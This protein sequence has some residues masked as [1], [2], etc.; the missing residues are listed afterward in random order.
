MSSFSKMTFRPANEDDI[1]QLDKW[2]WCYTDADL[3]VVHGWRAKGVETAVAE[4]GGN[5]VGSL[6]GKVAVVAVI[7]PFIHDPDAKGPDIYA[8]VVGMERILAYEGAAAG[9][10]EAYI[11]VPEQLVDYIDIV[12]RAGYEKTAEKC[13]ILRRNIV[14]ETHRRLGPERDKVLADAQEAPPQTLTIE[15]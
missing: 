10:L 9:A 1:E 2:R 14:P 7:D 6:T 8:A 13:V 4:K 15:C 12:Q 3:E 5:L 11:A